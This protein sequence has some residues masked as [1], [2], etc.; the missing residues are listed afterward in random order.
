MAARAIQIGEAGAHAAAAVAKQRQRR[1]WDQ[2]RLAQLV[3]DAGRPMSASV[4]GKIESGTRRVDVDDLV[5]IAAAL[6]VPPAQ[7]LPGVQ[8]TED[9]DPFEEAAAPGTVKARALDDIA[10]LG[11]LELLDAT[12]PTLAALAVRLAAEIDAPA[13]LGNSLQGMSKE[14][15][16]VLAELR[17]LA[18]E[19]PDDDDDGDDL[20]TPE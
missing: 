2:S 19:E 13:S 17:S 10:A 15:R 12:A 9:V 6:D 3:T 18:P 11:D 7:L 8:A 16:Q 1:G 14:L 5:V 20:A 4:L